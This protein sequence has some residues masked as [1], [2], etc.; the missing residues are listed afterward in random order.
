MSTWNGV[1]CYLISGHFVLFPVLKL[2]IRVT[3][4][5]S[6]VFYSLVFLSNVIISCFSSEYFYI[7]ILLSLTGV[8]V[9]SGTLSMA[10]VSLVR[11]F[12]IH[13]PISQEN[14]HF[15]QR[16]RRLLLFS[17]WFLSVSTSAPLLFVRSV[18]TYTVAGHTFSFCLEHWQSPWMRK[19]FSYMIFTTVYVVPSAILLYCHLKVGFLI[20]S[21][22]KTVFTSDRLASRKS[23]NR[24]GFRVK[25][26]HGSNT[27]SSKSDTHPTGHTISSQNQAFLNIGTTCGYEHTKN[28][29]LI[30]TPKRKENSIVSEDGGR[31]RGSETKNCSVC[32][33]NEKE[34]EGSKENGI[35]MNMNGHQRAVDQ[36]AIIAMDMHELRE[37][38][39]SRRLNHKR[40]QVC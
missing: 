39:R 40:K 27:N 1:P 7:I 12:L 36:A 37:A 13:Y 9:T 35:I 34:E 22:E 6:L 10:S 38:R 20:R 4:R 21:Y 32:E 23:F 26:S 24:R 5:H 2:W 14:K 30:M 28:S 19:L 8:A 18:D 3:T 15:H 11:F 17:I 16:T 33:R 25:S 31:R 29:N